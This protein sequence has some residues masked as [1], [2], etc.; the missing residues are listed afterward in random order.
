[1][2]NIIS[3]SAEIK[4]PYI[5]SKEIENTHSDIEEKQTLNLNRLK[6]LRHSYEKEIVLYA[7][8]NNLNY[9]STECKY[10]KGAHRE[11]VRNFLRSIDSRKIMNIIR[12]GE[13][14]ITNKNKQDLS[15]KNG[16]SENHLKDTF[17]INNTLSSEDKGIKFNHQLNEKFSE[18]FIELRCK[19]C[20]RSG[21]VMCKVCLLLENLEKM[22]KKNDTFQK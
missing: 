2:Y 5:V 22:F 9:F 8:H 7:Y 12:S 13:W 14:F 3:D 11:Y 10:A 4:K 16:S 15:K 1:K 21:S 19:K 18:K 20:G 6:P 17:R